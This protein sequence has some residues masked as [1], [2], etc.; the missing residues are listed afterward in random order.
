MKKAIGEISP[1]LLINKTEAKERQ[2]TM[3]TSELAEQKQAANHVCKL[4][5]AFCGIPK[6]LLLLEGEFRRLNLQQ[7]QQI[8]GIPLLVCGH[9]F[10]RVS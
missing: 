5:G 4:V 1:K 9:L 8:Q 10:W 6:G 3:A 7:P 2:E